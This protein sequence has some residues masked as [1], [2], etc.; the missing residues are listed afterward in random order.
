VVDWAAPI[1]V[2]WAAPVAAATA[3]VACPVPSAGE[4]ALESL[5]ETS[6]DK[7]AH[8]KEE[9]AYDEEAYYAAF[10]AKLTAAFHAKGYVCLA[11]RLDAIGAP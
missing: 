1:I 5:S 10:E 8:C 9:A 7:E 11:T 2:D 4:P 6:D 3:T